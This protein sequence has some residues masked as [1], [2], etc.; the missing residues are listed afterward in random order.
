MIERRYDLVI[1]GAGPA[2]YIAAL[3]AAHRGLHVA[4][5][6]KRST[7]G[8]TCLNVG[9]IP[10]KALLQVTEQYAWM[11]HSAK[12]QG[13]E[14]SSLSYN[15]PQIM[16]R[17]QQIVAGLVSGISSLFK[18]R[19][20]AHIQGQARLVS[21]HTIEVEQG[22]SSRLIEAE[23]ILLATGSESVSLPFL[24]CD[25][26]IVLSSTEALELEAVPERL[27]IIGA[28]VIGVEFA[29]IYSRLG[30]QVTV[31]EMLDKICPAIDVAIANILLQILQKQKIRFRLSSKVE[32]AL[33][34]DRAVVLH[35]V[36]NGGE[37]FDLTADLLLVAVG[38]RPCSAHLGLEQ[39]GIQ[40]TA[41]GFVRVDGAFRTSHPHIFAIGDLIE[42]P[43][44]AHR[45]S[46]EA[47]ACIE[48]LTGHSC[49]PVEYQCIP[50]VIYT[51]PE[52]AVVGV[53]E[54]EAEQA[55]LAVTI[56]TAPFRG[57][58][59]AR[60][61]GDVDGMV[62]IVGDRVSGRLLGVHIIGSHASE[63][64]GQAVMAL[65]AKISLQQ[66]AFT[67]YAHPTLSEVIKEAAMAALGTPL[68]A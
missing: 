63:I 22:G 52:V 55:G 41:E 43:M 10:S 68:H 16:R 14:Y 29:S 61:S 12:E 60:C 34:E 20:I 11:Q 62:K 47:I 54:E 53:T 27:A 39:I 48:I 9:C 3:H 50:N 65:H 26:K 13:V 30:S 67:C 2:G 45:A 25:G 44:L 31:I 64:I 19:A 7:L 40:I 66:L 35:I 28:G 36:P 42:G 23:H 46:T 56:G 24:P 33:I 18:R 1:I 21:A 17:K 6:E 37:P 8:G 59:R 57:N 15:F 51:H 32:R 5:I 58:P 38:R 49:P 4:C